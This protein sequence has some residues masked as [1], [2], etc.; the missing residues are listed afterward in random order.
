MRLPTSA[1]STLLSFLLLAIVAAL[2]GP[3]RADRIELSRGGIAARLSWQTV[4]DPSSLNLAGGATIDESGAP[5]LPVE[6][7]RI[8]LP[9]GHRASSVQIRIEGWE[10]I[11]DVAQLPLVASSIN[12]E[13]DIVAQ[14][15]HGDALNYRPGEIFPAS[16]ALLKGTALLHGYSIAYVDVFP[17][18][19]LEDGRLE[20]MSGYAVELSTLLDEALEP[21]LRAVAWP[22]LEESDRAAVRQIVDNPNEL[23]L[24]APP[25][26]IDPALRAAEKT[27]L[28]LQGPVDYLIVTVP[29]LVAEFQPLADDRIRRGL[30]S[31]VVTTDW[32]LANY[33]QGA[34][35]QETVRAFL[36]QAYAEWGLQYVLFGGDADVLAPRYV[37]TIYYPV[38]SYTDIP[39]D[40]Y[41]AALDGNWNRNGNGIYGDAYLDFLNTG[42]DVDFI[43][44]LAFGRAPVR[45]PAE[46]ALFVDKTLE[47]EAPTNPQ[48]YGNALFFSEVLFPSAWNGV[49]PINLDGATYSENIIFNS[50]LGGGNLVQ[51]F[52][53]YE[54]YNAYFGAEAETKAACMDSMQ[55]GHFG[56]VNHIG[57]GFYYNA[58]VGDNN[59]FVADAA[60]LNNG[61]NYFFLHA[62]NCSSSA[63]DFEC[64]ME[65]FIRNPNGGSVATIGSARS[66]F[67]TTADKYQQEF[68]K[69]LYVENVLRIG[70]AVNQA[71]E[72]FTGSAFA[73]TVDRWTQ[74]VYTLLGDPALRLWRGVPSVP[75]VTHPVSVARGAQSM[76]VD[77]DVGGGGLVAVSVVAQGPNGRAVRGTT[78]LSGQVT[79]DLQDLASGP[80]SIQLTCSGQG[81]QPFTASIPIAAPVGGQV[82]TSLESVNDD[83]VAPSAGDADGKIDA[84]ETVELFFRFQNNGSGSS[85]NGV[86]ATL[87]DLQAQP[88]VTV[89][90][91]AI[92]VGTLSGGANVVDNE[93]FVVSFAPTVADGKVVTLELDVTDGVTHWTED[94]SIVVVAPQLA[95]TRLRLDDTVSGNG[96]GISQVGETMRLYVE[97]GNFGAGL[98]NSVTGVLSTASGNV[99]LID[100]N[101]S[102]SALNLK[103]PSEGVG[104][105]ALSESNVSSENFVLLTLT[106]EHGRQLLHWFELRKPAA[107]ATPQIDTSLGVNT[108]ALR[109]DRQVG[110]PHFAGYRFYRSTAVS[111]PFQEQTEFALQ[112]TGFFHD[113]GL[114]P[115]T[116]Y[117]YYA[118]TVDSFAVEGPGSAVVSASTS[119]PEAAGGFPIMLGREL[120]GPVAVGDMRGDGTLVAT[121]GADFLY[122]IDSGGQ[123]LVD[124]DNDSQT[125]GPLAGPPAPNNRFTPSG[126]TLAD[127]DGDGSMELIGSNWQNA[128]LY[129]VRDDG[130]PFPGWP[131]SIGSRSWGTPAVGD[132]DDNGDLEIVVNTVSAWTYVFNHDGTDFYD[133]DANP[134]TIGR[135]HSRPGES[136]NRST[137]ALLDVDNDGTLELLFGS[138]IRTGADNFVYAL[139]NNATNATG[140]PKNLG[141]SGYNVGSI[142]CADM[143]NDLTMEIVFLCDNDQMY[144]WHPSGADKAGF[145]KAFISNAGNRDSVT[146][147]PAFG[148]FDGDGALEMVVVSIVGADDAY[149]SIMN[150]DGTV[151]PGWPQ[152]VPGLSEGSPVVGDLNGDNSPDVVFGIGGGGD[153]NPDILFA[154]NDDATPVEGFPIYLA[155]AAKSTPVITDFDVDGDVDLVFAGFDRFLHV[156]DMPFPYRAKH[157]YWPTFHGNNHRDGVFRV[158]VTPVGELE[159]ALSPSR[160][161]VVVRVLADGA[162]PEKSNWALDRRS[163]AGE[164]EGEWQPLAERL[165]F[166]DGELYFLDRSVSV[167]SSYR[168]RVR[169]ASGSQ[170]ATSQKY[171]APAVRLVLEQNSPNPF[172]PSTTLWFVVPGDASAMVP[173]SLIVHDLAGRAVRTLHDGPLAAGEQR[174]VWNGTD[175]SGAPVA[176]GTYVALLRAAG[177]RRSVKMTLLK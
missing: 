47:Y 26:G 164:V 156:W 54:N 25:R 58:S 135:F 152:H 136:F 66:A 104:F 19:V 70:D 78:A 123:E 71:R 95:V 48:I 116:R 41:F 34:D 51:S 86:T 11:G 177:E 113:I 45:T 50:I 74:F 72:G 168:Y 100:A 12:S 115:L 105:F 166:V 148:D 16:P 175:E 153:G 92:S 103:T 98:T 52:R 76:L 62:L 120:S 81:I 97:L 7:L 112:R 167:G 82:A 141:P 14:R 35:M 18:R 2:A 55:T 99:T 169:D 102:W 134:A 149:V 69:K 42:D 122:A 65:T 171:F 173:T 40:L 172:N 80:G 75:T 170:S 151:W 107:P 67:P 3:A 73:E 158:L 106:D 5:A 163:V 176:S 121:F 15:H 154:W 32:I 174:F 9:F 111:G 22:G 118:S 138:H 91:G 89:L 1:S 29:E 77:V 39:A 23:P 146:P 63:F 93:P 96:D 133:G 109:T 8:S 31:A 129:I 159:F 124:G 88:G 161:G 101:N 160:D 94:V 21:A 143:D 139:K 147:S 49:D 17:V 127:L 83:N 10:P 30:S 60:L 68:Y 126:V 90:D 108:I 144:V 131:K 79:L 37:R 24:H 110:E 33:R 128:Q 59:I 145:P 38:G 46:V 4:G 125:L 162:L 155:G 53:L 84:G 20:R 61:P 142:S 119:P 85:L 44:E 130:S 43:A 27:P 165:T 64:L 132:L 28:I 150:H 56:L 157:S 87:Q 137:P 114:E 140:W 117:Y 13:G 6:T 36:K 57:H